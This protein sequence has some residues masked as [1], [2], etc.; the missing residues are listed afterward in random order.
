MSSYNED[1]YFLISWSMNMPQIRQ[2]EV[3]RTTVYLTPR[4]RQRLADLRR[5]EKTKVLNEAL[6]RVFSEGEER[7]EFLK[8]LE[9]AKNF[10]R[11]KPNMPSE[12]VLRMLRDG[13]EEELDQLTRR[14]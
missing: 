3:E 11:V 14:S 4:N 2:E 10:S 9:S 5:G 12:Q 8:F 6:D 13:Q 7:K 1:I